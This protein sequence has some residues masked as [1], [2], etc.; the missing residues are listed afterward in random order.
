MKELFQYCAL[1]VASLVVFTNGYSQSP[2]DALMMEPRQACILLDYNYSSFNQYWEGEL[3][4]ENQTIATVYRNSL[5]PMAAVG[6]TDQL[7]FFVGV[8]FIKSASTNPNGGKFAGVSAFQDLTIAAKYRW[9]KHEFEKGELSAL[10]TIGFSTPI[11]NYLPDY[12]PYSIGLGAPELSYRAILQYK[13]NNGWYLRGA[14]A[15]LWR[16]YAEAERE[17]Y[18]NDGSYYTSWMDVPN[19]F[20]FEGVAGKWLFNDKLQVEINYFSSYS[21]SGD[22]IRLYNAAQPT[23]D[24]DMGRIGIFVHYFFPTLKGFGIVVYQNQTI[25]G[26]NAALLKTAGVGVNYFF[27]Y[28][29]EKKVEK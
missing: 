26:Q 8:P 4:R 3:K 7:N 22:D 11:T 2:S 9:L 15:Y 5:M 20:T 19:A 17:Y 24:V 10:A 27:N 28:L 1:V 6:I 23:N 12:M 29:K 14:G 25:W 16:G 21:L 13:L 18:Y